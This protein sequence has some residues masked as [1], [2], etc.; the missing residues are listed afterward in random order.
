MHTV[1]MRFSCLR[2]SWPA[3]PAGHSWVTSWSWRE[4]AVI[5]HSGGKPPQTRAYLCA[6][7]SCAS[8]SWDP[9]YAGI[10]LPA[11]F[12]CKQVLCHSRNHLW[13]HLWNIYFPC[14]QE[15]RKQKA[16]II[17]ME[18]LIAKY[19]IIYSLIVQLTLMRPPR[20]QNAI[21]TFHKI[22]GFYFRLCLDASMSPQNTGDITLQEKNEGIH[23]HLKYPL[24]CPGALLWNRKGFSEHLLAA[25]RYTLEPF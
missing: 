8:P 18:S 7:I 10:S 3:W 17:L 15:K 21:H 1:P 2:K 25:P 14:M 20:L 6:V 22:G 19:W 12:C 9:A 13:D 24:T 23:R 16:C 5:Y 4:A 11:L